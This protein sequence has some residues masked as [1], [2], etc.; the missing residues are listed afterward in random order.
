M[1]FL[2]SGVSL[3][4]QYIISWDCW[5]RATGSRRHR[6]SAFWCQPQCQGCAWWGNRSRVIWMSSSPQK[7]E[8]LYCGTAAPFPVQLKRDHQDWEGQNST[9]III[10]LESLFKKAVQF[11]S[12]VSATGMKAPSVNWWLFFQCG[13]QACAGRAV[14]HHRC[15]SHLEKQNC[16]C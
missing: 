14:L 5:G 10:Q 6:R 12:R 13:S 16:C 9:W 7:H 4:H 8:E 15:V 3:R 2:V 11:L 1:L